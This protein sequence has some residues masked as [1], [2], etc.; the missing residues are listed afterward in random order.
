[1][2]KLGKSLQSY[3][4]QGLAKSTQR[5]YT[6][7]KSRFMAF[8]TQACTSPLPLSESVLCFY[9]SHLADEGLAHTTIKSYLSACRHLHIS[10]GYS[11][12]CIGDMPRLAQ[13]MKGIKA[14]QA[15]QG[16]RVKPRLPIT[17]SILTQIKSFLNKKPED[18]DNI[19]AWAAYTTCFFGFLRAGEICIPSDSEYDS[20]AHLSFSDIAVDSPTNPTIMQVRIKSSKTD[21]F[22]KGV[23][24]YLGRT[25]N[26]PCPITAMMAYLS[27]RG[28]TAGPLFHFKDGKPLTRD[29]FVNKLRD[30]LRNIGIC[31]GSYSG[32]SFRAGAA[33]TAAQH[34]IPDATIQLLGRLQSTAYL[35]Y[36][37]TPRDKLA[38]ITA[39]LS[40]S[41]K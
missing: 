15:K 35:V 32:H 28:D 40:T 5:T 23:D 3:Y 19:M 30:T 39:T 31:Q 14:S 9:V 2:H 33:T 21:P 38:S 12:P 25:H 36:I 41:P 29:R 17:P 26:S 20:G 7:A 16:R 22:R 24:I 6:S 1:M 8:C 4:L 34:G 11:E 18:F 27:V 13:V 37:K 10:H